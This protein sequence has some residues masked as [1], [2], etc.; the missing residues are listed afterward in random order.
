M[1]GPSPG[2]PL[3]QQPGAA[4]ERAL[5]AVGKPIRY[6]LGHGGMH[7]EDAQPTRDGLCD[8]SGFAMWALGL[9]RFDGAVWWDT[10]R[11]MHDAQHERTRFQSQDWLAAAPGDLVVYG[12]S[13]DAAGN[14]R[15]GHV[16][17]VSVVD[18]NGP[19]R[20]VHCSKGNDTVFG[21]AVCETGPEKFRA[22]GIVARH[23]G[24]AA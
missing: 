20:V 5:S 17:V 14:A 1:T 16:G 4:V 21:F 8:C 3:E 13:R 6:G 23:A 18:S 22:R 9:S 2:I 11:I 15:Q 24:R 12:D 10:T 19:L 7:P